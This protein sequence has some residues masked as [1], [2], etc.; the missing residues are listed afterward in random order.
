MKK[1]KVCA[2]G[3]AE[4]FLHI[5]V[6]DENA[7]VAILEFPNDVL[8]VLYRNR[9]NASERLVEH[10]ELWVDGKASRNLASATLATR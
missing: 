6:S 9:V 7:D 4:R 1:Q 2:V 8:N 3:D 5:V 10:Y